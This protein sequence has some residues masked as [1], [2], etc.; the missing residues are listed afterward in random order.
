MM[1]TQQNDTL[2]GSEVMVFQ[3]P[4]SRLREEGRAVI[5]R[6]VRRGK[7]GSVEWVDCWVRFVGDPL[8]G[9]CYRTIAYV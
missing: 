3:D 5:R 4:F 9:D 1:A 2:I 8:S 6:V 7:E